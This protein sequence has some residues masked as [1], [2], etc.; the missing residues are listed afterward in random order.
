MQN[1]GIICILDQKS[2]IWQPDIV[3]R[4]TCTRAATS[5]CIMHFFLHSSRKPIPAMDKSALL[6]T[7]YLI[8]ADCMQ[9]I[10]HSRLIYIEYPSICN[11]YHTVRP[12]LKTQNAS[13]LYKLRLGGVV[14]VSDVI[15]TTRTSV[16]LNVY[17]SSVL[18]SFSPSYEQQGGVETYATLSIPILIRSERNLPSRSKSTGGSA[19]RASTPDLLGT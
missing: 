15:F 10:A 14:S 18:S 2:I 4:N 3:D 12:I 17:T 5:S 19:C 11:P 16:L 9:A 6:S 13:Q 1:T 8:Q 7:L